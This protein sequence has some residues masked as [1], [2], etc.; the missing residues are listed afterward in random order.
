MLL[1]CTVSDE[2]S[3]NSHKCRVVTR[4]L[5]KIEKFKSC[6]IRRVEKYN[7][8]PMLARIILPRLPHADTYG[9]FITL[10][11]NICADCNMHRQT[12]TIKYLYKYC[13]CFLL[14]V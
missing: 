9:Q 12:H 7:T 13:E 8:F 3:K 1:V 5:H 4:Y 6:T 11:L 10:T 14:R 2:I